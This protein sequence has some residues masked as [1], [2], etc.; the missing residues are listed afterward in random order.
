MFALNGIYA[1]LIADGHH[2]DNNVI[3]EAFKVLGFN[4]IIVVSDFLSVKGLNDGNYYYDGFNITKKW[5]MCYL[6]ESK[7]IAG[8][9]FSYL[10]IIIKRI[11]KISKCCLPDIV[12]ISSYKFYKSVGL[13]CQYG[14][15]Q[16][17][18]IADL[19]I[20]DNNLNLKETIK[21]GVNVY[22]EF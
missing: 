21:N 6:Q 8:S 19:I 1:E 10:D 18:Y 14:C 4:R 7:T 22:K 15:I 9:T 3:L 5:Q 20:V 16:E 12:K 17:N 13:S 2:I 11:K